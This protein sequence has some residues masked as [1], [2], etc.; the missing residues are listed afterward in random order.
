MFVC[1]FFVFLFGLLLLFCL[2]IMTYDGMT[3]GGQHIS[4]II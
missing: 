4:I 3:H 2:W 1:L